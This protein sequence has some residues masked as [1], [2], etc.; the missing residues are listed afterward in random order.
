MTSYQMGGEGK[1]AK[2]TQVADIRSYRKKNN[3]CL[4][5][6][7]NVRVAKN[8]QQLNIQLSALT[9]RGDYRGLYLIHSFPPQH[10]RKTTVTRVPQ[11]AGNHPAVD[12]MATI[13]L[14]AAPR[15]PFTEL[16]LC[17]A[18]TATQQGRY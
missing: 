16:R 12:V 11:G 5:V 4:S 14:P 1:Q 8:L 15:L 17:D 10:L 9:W 3:K 18:V 13:T 2:T 6:Y 7:F